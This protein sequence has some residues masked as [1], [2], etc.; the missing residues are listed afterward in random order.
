MQ[1]FLIKNRRGL[2]IVGEILVSEKSIGLA[3]VLHGLGGVPTA[4]SHS[5]YR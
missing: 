1:K 5:N 4:K 3:F 2:E